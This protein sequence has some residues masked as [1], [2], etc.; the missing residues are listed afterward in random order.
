M[1]PVAGGSDSGMPGT[2]PVTID[3]SKRPIV[4]ITMSLTCGRSSHHPVAEFPPYTNTSW[5]SW[6]VWKR[7]HPEF[8]NCHAALSMPEKV[9]RTL[10]GRVTKGDWLKTKINH[11]LDFIGV[12]FVQEEPITDSQSTLNNYRFTLVTAHATSDWRMVV[13]RAEWWSEYFWW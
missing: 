12:C 10:A 6:I 9:Q 2:L 11:V 7:G 13:M 1:L 5:R 3:P 4:S 8:V